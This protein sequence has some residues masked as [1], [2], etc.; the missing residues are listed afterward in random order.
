M[1]KEW[2]KC[3]KQVGEW[4]LW[5]LGRQP[6]CPQEPPEPDELDTMRGSSSRRS[7]D[8]LPNT[9]TASRTPALRPAPAPLKETR[10]IE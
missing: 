3:W 2:P 9:L 7:R 10:K 5:K 1:D 6:L 8:T 4:E